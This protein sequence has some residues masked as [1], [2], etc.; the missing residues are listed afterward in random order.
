MFQF[1]EEV[2]KALE[3]MPVPLA[4]Y[5]RDGGRIVATLVSDGL[6]RMMSADRETLLGLLNGNLFERV[7]PDDAGRL[8]RVVREFANRLCGYD[9]IYRGKYDPAGDYHY[10]HSIGRFQE[11]PDGSALAVVVYTDISASQSESSLLVENY[12]LFQKDHF[13]SDPLTGLPNG[14]FLHKF[15]DAKVDK[16]RAGGKAA[17]LLYFD[18][19]GL[20]SYNSQYGYARGDDLLRLIADVLKDEFPSGMIARGADDHFIVI[21]EYR[22]AE[23]LAQRIE[24]A[25]RKVRS[26]AFGNTTGIQAGICLYDAAIDTST[27]ME[28]ARHAHKQ[29]G[30]DLN[31][32]YAIYTH[33]TDD[34]YW[35]QRYIV[36]TFDTAL[37]QEWI[38]IYYQAIMRVST[39]RAAALEALARWVDP[40]RGIISPG[41]FIPVLEKYHLLYKLDLYMVEQFLKEYPERIRVGLPIIPV[42][43]NFSAQDFDHVDIVGALNVL[44][45]HHGVGK[46]N[47]IIEITEQDVATASERFK[48]QLHDLRNN[49]YRL[50][51]DDFGS[52][53][54]S[55]NVLSQFDV[56]VIKIDLEFLRHLDDHNGAN[57]HI[58][59]SIVDVADKLGIRTLVEGM[60]TSEHLAFLREIGCEFAQ[61][62]YYYRPESLASI[63]FKI[64]NGNPILSCET[65]EE[66]RRLR[67]EWA[68]TH[69]GAAQ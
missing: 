22:D 62:F 64:R 37:E 26:G 12:A 35:S 15:A 16:I 50:W 23:R 25:N 17:A 59:K 24:S 43:I 32:T 30:N 8:A 28:Y 36:E 69:S 39:G 51:F 6:C 66:R 48:Q 47:V 10:I 13:Y 19:R 14:N 55:L 38:K 7:H 18:V 46:E 31:V 4:Y 5:Q 65:P 45:E 27:A 56:D 29:I 42:S 58:M 33:E 44:F 21:T 54:S 41:E 67:E 2:R 52:G 20:R 57:R 53:Y 40:V 34:Q 60:E 11:T 1:Q 61:G 63:S 49:G 68:D 3:I 9:V